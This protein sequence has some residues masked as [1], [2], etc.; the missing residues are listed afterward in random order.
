[1]QSAQIC[2]FPGGPNDLMIFSRLPLMNVRHSE[3]MFE[4]LNSSD[5]V[6]SP[7]LGRIAFFEMPVPN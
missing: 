1:M 3:T 7:D 6:F 5:C 2:Q 4:W